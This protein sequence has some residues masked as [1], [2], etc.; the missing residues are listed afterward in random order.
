M[1][2]YANHANQAEAAHAFAAQRQLAGT[3]LP[4]NENDYAFIGMLDAYRNSGGLARAQEVFTLF[5]ARSDMDVMTLAH[6]IAQRAVLSLEWH[7]DVWVPLFQFELQH[8]AV[9]RA[10]AP[11]LAVLNPMCTPWELAHWCA[12]P[13]RLLDGQSPASALDAGAN[14]VLRAACADRFSLL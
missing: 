13:H 7:A 8:M 6:S 4:S 3:R 9:K 12:Q 14:Q 11:V 10:L 1:H 2:Y 5:K